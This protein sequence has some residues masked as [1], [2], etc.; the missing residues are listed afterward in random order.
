MIIKRIESRERDI[1][2]LQ[3]LA[4]RP[5]A[6]GSVRENIEKEII[7]IR[8]GMKGEAE[9]AY[10]M[11]FHYGNSMNW[12]ILH[13]LRIDCEGRIAQI[14]HLLINRML[15]VYVCESKHFA[16][17]VSINTHGEFT[18]FFGGRPYGVPS[19]IEQNRRH[20]AVLEAAFKSGLVSPP[21][22]LGF[23]LTPRLL[24][25]VLVS[26]GARITRPRKPV[27][28]LDDIIKCDQLKSKIDKDNEKTSPLALTKVVG[29]E[30]LL[31]FAQSLAAVH[32]PLEF[33]WPARFG[34]PPDAPQR[35]EEVRCPKAPYGSSAAPSK[36]QNRLSNKPCASPKPAVAQSE[37]PASSPGQAR[38]PRPSTPQTEHAVQAMSQA[39]SDTP[40]QI[41][42]PPACPKN[43]APCSKSDK[44]GKAQPEYW[45]FSCR[46][47]VAPQIAY[48]CWDNR[49][50]FNGKVYCEKCQKQYPEPK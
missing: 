2:T 8:A 45:C 12:M 1:K 44:K 20:I 47:T 14:D 11:E 43:D 4:A 15:E 5:D 13:D 35:P 10:E 34:L 19:P 23:K 37:A 17:G 50:R 18:A 42:A 30:T 49:A 9:A 24:G 39:K 22:R 38:V 36:V 32:T 6:R 16:E 21:K 26:K 40:R 46:K 41:S 27:P 29:T 31:G 28:G 48:S 25:L 33:N 7:R 3:E